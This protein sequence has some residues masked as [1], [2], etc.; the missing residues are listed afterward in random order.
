MTYRCAA[1]TPIKGGQHCPKCGAR[2]N[3]QCRRA[4]VV[5]RIEQAR[6]AVIDAAEE[7]VLRRSPAVSAEK[8]AGAVR[9]LQTIKS[10]SA[11][12][13]NAA[14]DDPLAGIGPMTTSTP[15]TS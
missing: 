11:T 1:G 4:P 13:Q 3:E 10:C 6:Q 9:W 12:A 14:A 2:Q 5:T 15:P 8:L 7:W